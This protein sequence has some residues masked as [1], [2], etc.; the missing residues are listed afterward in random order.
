M[1]SGPP[2]SLE[3]LPLHVAAAGGDFAREGLAVTL[4]TVRS[5]VAAAEALARGQIDLAATSLEAVLRFAL[6]KDAP[7]PQLVFGLTAAP[8]VALLAA[9]EPAGLRGLEGLRGVKLGISTPGAPEL[10]WLAALLHRARLRPT[11]VDLTALGARG[12]AAALGSG[13]VPAALVEEPFADRLLREGRFAL[14]VDLRTPDAVRQALGEPTVS[15]AIFARRDRLPDG[16]TLGALGRALLA[17]RQRLAVSTPA[18]LAADLPREVVGSPEDFADRV[19]AARRLYLDGRVTAEQVRTSIRLIRARMPL[20][21]GVKPPPPD[22]FLHVP[23]LTP[24]A[25]AG[26]P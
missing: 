16:A 1:V 24:P 19:Q 5:E 3:Y 21:P 22:D 25:P 7:Q 14:L 9:R 13:A 17:A 8:P 23:P 26:R 12:A 15:A 4:Q 18:A 20:A 2:T 11:D 10:A 6:R